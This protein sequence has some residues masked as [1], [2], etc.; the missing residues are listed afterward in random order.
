M[1]ATGRATRQATGRATSLTRKTA[2]A[3]FFAF[4]F[5]IAGCTSPV[6]G[7]VDDGEADRIVVALGRAGIDAQKEA[8]GANDGKFA[9]NVATSRSA[10]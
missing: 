2:L 7:S 1:R 5:V 6:A 10:R 3:V 4:S 8:D 9:V